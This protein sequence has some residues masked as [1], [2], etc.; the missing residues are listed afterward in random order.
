YRGRAPCHG[1]G[2]DMNAVGNGVDRDSALP[3]PTR[4]N[5]TTNPPFLCFLRRNSSSCLLHQV[6]SAG[7][8]GDEEGRQDGAA[9]FADLVQ[10]AALGF[11]KNPVSTEQA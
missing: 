6:V 4:M 5:C 7:L 10:V 11:V 1:T 2:G 3:P 8:P 9:G